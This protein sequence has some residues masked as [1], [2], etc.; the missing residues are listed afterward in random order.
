MPIFRAPA[1]PA[2]PPRPDG[3]TVRL[4]SVT[5]A[6]PPATR[7]RIAVIALAL[8]VCALVVAAVAAGLAWQALDRASR[9]I[10][11]VAPDPGR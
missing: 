6:G 5:A 10:T 4:S 1:S 8:A 11:S 9:P 7:N 2:V 3:P